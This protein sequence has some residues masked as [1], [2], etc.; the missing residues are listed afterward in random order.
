MAEGRRRQDELAAKVLEDIIRELEKAGRAPVIAALLVNRA[1][2]IT[3]LLEYSLAFADHVAVA[4]GLAVREALRF[5]CRRCGIDAVE[6]DEK[7]LPG[8][9]AETLRISTAEV[10]AHL[11]MLGVTRSNSLSP[12]VATRL[13][14]GVRPASL[15]HPSLG[16]GREFCCLKS[17][18]ENLLQHP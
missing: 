2:W 7:T 16:S 15:N 8:V 9:A 12:R 10:D 3:D 5:A 17:R 13:E 4:E 1:G 18:H 14:P 11:K 6:L